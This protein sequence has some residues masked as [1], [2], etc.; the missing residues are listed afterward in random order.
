VSGASDHKIYAFIGE[1]P[2]R[3]NNASLRTDFA[4]SLVRKPSNGR[5][6]RGGGRLRREDNA[7]SSASRSWP[8]CAGSLRAGRNRVTEAFHG[9]WGVGGGGSAGTPPE[10]LYAFPSPPP[11]TRLTARAARVAAAL[12]ELPAAREGRVYS[13]VIHPK[14]RLYAGADPAWVSGGTE[15]PHWTNRSGPLDRCLRWLT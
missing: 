11:A 2:G 13:N 14:E 4:V 8:C 7:A 9:A 12:S 5:G 15:G 6:R 3:G 1:L 10:F